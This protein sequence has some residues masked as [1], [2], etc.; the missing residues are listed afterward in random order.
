MKKSNLK[1]NYTTL[2]LIATG[3]TFIIA[4][5]IIFLPEFLM[6][7]KFCL[8]VDGAYSFN[9]KEGHLCNNKTISRYVSQMEKEA[10]WA[11]D[12]SMKPSISNETLE[13]IYSNLYK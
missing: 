7:R 1:E 12:D 11:F 3:L 6:A 10:F 13:N 8:S 2:F 4:S 5:F 9:F